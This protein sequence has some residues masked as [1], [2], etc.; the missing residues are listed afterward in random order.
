M[1][2]LADAVGELLALP[3]PTATAPSLREWQRT[4]TR[5]AA[6]WPDTALRAL[7]TGAHAPCVAFA[8]AA[9][10]Q[11]ALER[12][13]GPAPGSPFRAL[14]VT[15]MRGN[16]PRDITTALSRQ[17]GAWRLSGEKSFVTGGSVAA[18][19][20]IAARVEGAPAERPEL[21]MVC[22]PADR[23]GVTIGELAPLPYVTELPHARLL[24]AGV[25]VEDHEVLPGDGY[26]AY[27]KPFRTLEDIHVE[28]GVLGLL[29]RQLRRVPD[30]RARIERLLALVGSLHAASAI[31]PLD[32]ATHLLLAGQRAQLLSLLTELDGAWESIA[33]EF[34]AGW[35]RDSRLLSVAQ[36]ARDART[37]R[38]WST[39]DRIAGD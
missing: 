1:P 18:Q 7:V 31:A 17:D 37:Q 20:C 8:F 2:N 36:T 30:S 5:M 33:P 35:Q 32:P 9:G 12:M 21:R 6:A 3:D 28:L 11:A 10:Y 15:E 19:L 38:A 25:R 34:H 26:T 23:A 16:R 29:I 22:I 14:C 39:L 24:L 27:V 13:L 4:I